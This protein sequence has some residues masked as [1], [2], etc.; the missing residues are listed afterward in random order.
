[1]TS[2]TATGHAGRTI[3]IIGGL[4]LLLVIAAVVATLALDAGKPASYPAGSP[5]YAFQRYYQAFQTGDMQAAYAS[6]S[7]RVR[8][9]LS[10]DQYVWYA[11]KFQPPLEQSTVVRIDHVNRTNGVVTLYLAVER[12]SGSGLDV[13]RYTEQRS[14]RLVEEAGGW[15]IDEPLA[16]IE[17][18]YAL[19]PPA[20]PTATPSADLASERGRG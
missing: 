5:E 2:Q 18:I 16:G 9:Q 6:F 10:Y 17:V 3:A 8:D 4:V 15:K 7:Q 20:A 11:T 12:A 14:V 19:P 13:S 1:M